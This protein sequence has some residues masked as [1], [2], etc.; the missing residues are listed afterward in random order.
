M[1][2]IAHR[3]LSLLHGELDTLSCAARQGVLELLIKSQPGGT[4]EALC[5]LAPGAE[6]LVSPVQVAGRACGRWG[7]S[8][9]D[10]AGAVSAYG[11]AAG[12]LDSL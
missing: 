3:N 9:C 7:Q 1:Y 8:P 11:A 4:A 5:G 12:Q 6:L 10:M 2:D